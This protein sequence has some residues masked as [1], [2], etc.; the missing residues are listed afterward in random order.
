MLLAPNAA[1]FIVNFLLKYYRDG[2]GEVDHI[3]VDFG[4]SKGEEF[5][6]TFVVDRFR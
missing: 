6:V 1:G 4:M 3:D 2:V 5:T